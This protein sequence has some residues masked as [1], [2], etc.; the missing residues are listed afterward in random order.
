MKT[1]KKPRLIL[2]VFLAVLFAL[3]T[4][5]AAANAPLPIVKSS[6]DAIIAVLKENGLDREQKR[7]KIRSIVQERFDFIEMSKRILGTN[8]GTLSPGDQNAFVDRLKRLLEASYVN[9][10][11]SYTDEKVVFGDEIIKGR[12]A[13]VESKAITKTADIPID[14]VLIQKDGE[15]FVYDVI[16]ENVS[17]ISNYRST[18]NEIIKKSGFAHLIEEMDSKIQE[19]KNSPNPKG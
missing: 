17:L 2:S 19:L 9:K 7:E 8:W 15:W 14:Y 1:N 5:L 12:Y 16:I 4:N 6:V 11:E 13:K 18:Y 10:I 3:A